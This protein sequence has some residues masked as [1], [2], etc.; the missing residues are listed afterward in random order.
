MK[1]EL[2]LP[3][4]NSPLYR[5]I[6][7]QFVVAI[8]TACDCVKEFCSSLEEIVLSEVIRMPKTEKRKE[9]SQYFEQRWGL[10]QCLLLLMAPTFLFWHRWSSTQFFNQKGWYSIILQAVVDERGL[11]WNVYIGQPGSLHEFYVCIC[12]VGTG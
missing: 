11:F 6:A 10:A 1:R 3:C 12:T 5:N 2:L 4:G 7:H 8:S 9:L